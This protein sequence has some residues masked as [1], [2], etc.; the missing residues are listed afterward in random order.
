MASTILDLDTVVSFSIVK[1]AVLN[2]SIQMM[3]KNE[4]K[5]ALVSG[6][7]TGVGFQIA[8]ALADNGYKVYV[9]SRDLQKGES[10]VLEIG[11]NAK[12]IKLD[13]TDSDSI[14]SAREII[15]KEQGYYWR[16]RNS[17]EKG[18]R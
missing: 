11:D 3:Q 7:N 1:F 4:Q 15:E 5:V 6:A 10:A 17:W 14:L 12:A 9:G 13:I 8:K 16:I 2:L 18:G